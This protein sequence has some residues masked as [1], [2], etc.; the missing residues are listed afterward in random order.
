MALCF[1]FTKEFVKKTESFVN[2]LPFD[3]QN[4]TMKR[5]RKGRKNR[6]DPTNHENM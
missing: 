5:L 4:E 3:V 1:V 6:N 2:K